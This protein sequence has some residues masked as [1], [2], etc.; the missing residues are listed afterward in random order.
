M[1]SCD[2]GNIHFINM[3]VLKLEKSVQF[4]KISIWDFQVINNGKY[5]LMGCSDGNVRL[6]EIGT[7]NRAIMKGHTKEVLGVGVVDLD[8]TYIISASKDRYLKIWK[9]EENQK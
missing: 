9:K 4:G 3:N 6:W 2:D 1:V 5:L 8:Y 7:K